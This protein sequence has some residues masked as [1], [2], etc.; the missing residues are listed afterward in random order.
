MG[1][2]D[3]FLCRCRFEQ[4][5]GHSDLFRHSKLKADLKDT[6]AGTVLLPYNFNSREGHV[7]QE[8]ADNRAYTAAERKINAEY[9][10]LLKNYL[11][12]LLPVK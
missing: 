6:K 4:A 10:D 8:E 5:E 7:T 11:S 9:A 12:R 1:R 3:Q 2:R